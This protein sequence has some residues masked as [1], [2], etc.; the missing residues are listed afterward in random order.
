MRRSGWCLVSLVLACL[1][2]GEFAQAQ[3][4]GRRPRTRN[5]APVSQTAAQAQPEKEP[6]VEELLQRLDE[7]ERAQH[8]NQPAGQPTDRAGTLVM[9]LEDPNLASTNYYGP[10]GIPYFVARLVLINLADQPVTIKTNDVTLTADG[11]RHTFQDR[12]PQLE[13][14]PIQTGREMRSFN[15]LRPPEEVTIPSGEKAAAW[16][17]YSGLPGGPNVP[18]MQLDVKVGERSQSLDVNAYERGVLGLRTERLGPANCLALLTIGGELN[19]V[20]AGTLADELDALAAAGTARAV[21]AWADGAK[22]PGDQVHGWLLASVMP[23]QN[24]QYSQLPGL[25][26]FIRELHLAH[27]PP[28]TSDLG[29]LGDGTAPQHA[30]VEDAV[31]AGLRS[32]C[33]ALPRDELRREIAY[34]H[35][36][37]RA[38]ALLHGAG[39]LTDADVSLLLKC[40]AD[41]DEYVQRCALLALGQFGQPAAVQRLLEA[42]RSG[43]SPQAETAIAALAGSRYPQAHG[44]LQEYLTTAPADMRLKIVEILARHPRPMW[45][46]TIFGYVRDEDPKLRLAA[47]QALVRIGDPRL[48]DVLA[49]ALQS[50][51]A[52]LRAAAFAR[53]ADRS[54]GPSEA[55]AMD[56]A[57]DLLKQEAPSGPVVPLLTRTRDPRA[58]PLLLK[59]LD[60]RKEGRAPLIDLLANVGGPEIAPELLSRYP[61]FDVNEQATTLQKLIEL[62]VEGI[63]PL[64]VEALKSRK[65]ELV[66]A[67]A[68]YIGMEAEPGSVRLLAELLE[69]SSEA[70]VWA[71]LCNAL[72]M[73]GTAEARQALM[74]ARS[75]RDENLRNYAAN[76]FEQMKYN[77]PAYNFTVQAQQAIADDDLDRASEFLS[78]A[79]Q[80]DPD[81]GDAYSKRGHVR[82]KQSRND[83]ARADFAK[84]VEFDDHDHLAL[85]GLLIVDAMS[86]KYV[87]AVESLKASA[88]K[89]PDNALFEYNSACV[90]GRAL[91]Q[92]AKA[93]AS[94]ERDARA[95][96]YQVE[97]LAHLKRSLELGFNE[98]DWVGKDP[99]LNSLHEVPEFQEFLKNLP[100]PK[101]EEQIKAGRQ[102]LLPRGGQ[103]QLQFRV[104]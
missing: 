47:L 66:Q 102:I 21:I 2:A 77:S 99:D 93:E 50:D 18:K 57:L 101:T 76:S 73:I 46:E 63:R 61:S 15:D 74:K 98:T 89:F 29:Y 72:R 65:P 39:R 12:D 91:E 16:L 36:L 90:Y 92:V 103:L 8:G 55:L 14:F 56:Y 62:H 43:P 69:S 104:R 28:G 3:L 11:T 58:L 35:R 38:A 96:E 24:Q 17:L 83:E 48:Y 4:R 22:P 80:L 23:Q 13:K 78:V 97:A 94:A 52:E 68:Q 75:S 33:E 10:E 31:S 87:E 9:M 49:E 34:G 82:L 79:L 6:T 27:L 86:G 37:S 40:S 84:A 51:H 42:A 81:F 95:S 26:A 59:W 60:E 45:S 88:S 85:T 41:E 71:P 54:D 25:P 20:N 30:T 44:A 70:Y 100:E 7:L 53:L 19:A 64:A 67:A 1:V 32:A 5:R